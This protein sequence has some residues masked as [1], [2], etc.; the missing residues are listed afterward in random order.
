MSKTVLLFD[1]DGTLLLSGPVVHEAFLGTIAELHGPTPER[2]D[3]PFAGMTDRAIFARILAEMGEKDSDEAFTAFRTAY[4]ARLREVYPTATTPYLLPGVREL[5]EVLTGRD[6]VA[7]GLATGN[8]RDTA[9]VKL[10][11]F[12]LDTVFPTGGFGDVHTDRAELVR[13]AWNAT[14]GHHDVA[15]DPARVWV[16]GDTDRDVEAARRVGARVLGVRT[17]PRSSDLANA[18]RVVP[19]LSDTTE[20]L[21]ALLPPI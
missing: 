20:V 13:E 16:I 21:R 6:D 11:R 7:L 3:F 18:D 8:L 17:G 5:V 12:R 1:I 10:G 14:A 4:P 19:D 9:Y 2:M 15:V